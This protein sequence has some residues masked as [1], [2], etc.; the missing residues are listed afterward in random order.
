[1]FN[2]G[3]YLLRFNKGF[4][5][6]RGINIVNLQGMCYLSSDDLQQ[7]ADN[8]IVIMQISAGFPNKLRVCPSC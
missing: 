3:E 1:M 7:H 4:T 6:G 8:L 5:E 2:L